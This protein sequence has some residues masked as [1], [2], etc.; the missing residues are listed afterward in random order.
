VRRV[1]VAANAATPTTSNT[2]T[3]AMIQASMH[4]PFHERL[5]THR[6][7]DETVEE[8][9]AACA[10]ILEVGPDGRAHTDRV[11]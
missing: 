3:T 5:T 8:D 10:R 6:A 7:R 2:M 4:G 9:A 11:R 1:R